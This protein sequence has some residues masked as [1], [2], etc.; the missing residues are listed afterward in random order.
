[1]F[2]GPAM[3]IGNSQKHIIP[4][5]SSPVGRCD[6][7]SRLSNSEKLARFKIAADTLMTFVGEVFYR[8]NRTEFYGHAMFIAVATYLSHCHVDQTGVQTV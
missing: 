8:G 7:M 6:I 4:Y 2:Y 3:F 5:L 1:M